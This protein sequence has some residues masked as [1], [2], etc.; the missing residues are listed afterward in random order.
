MPKI[1]QKRKN[2]SKSKT[3]SKFRKTKN[4][5]GGKKYKEIWCSQS[6][7]NI[8]RME[9]IK[10]HCTSSKKY[11]DAVIKL[12]KLNK[13]Y[14]EFVS[15]KCNIRINYDYGG[16]LWPE[17]DEQHKCSSEQRKSKLFK[18]ILKL[19]KEVSIH[20]CEDKHCA[21]EKKYKDECTDLGEEQCR[22]KYK[23]LIENMKKT[24]N[25]KILSLKKCF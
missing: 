10:K 3:S 6:I 7:V 22:I 19:E 24:K 17:T 11:K 12:A 21:K 20:K 23:D 9:C 4:Q 16:E 1:S 5:N 2:I 13:E 25:K 8:P 15:K 18:N 14:D